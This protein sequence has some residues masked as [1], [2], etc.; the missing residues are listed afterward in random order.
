MQ[1]YKLNKKFKNYYTG[2]IES[3][4]FDYE[5][6]SGFPSIEEAKNSVLCLHQQPDCFL[7]ITFKH[8]IYAISME[9]QQRQMVIGS[10]KVF[11]LHNYQPT[12]YQNDPTSLLPF[13]IS[14]PRI[15]GHWRDGILRDMERIEGSTLTFTGEKSLLSDQFTR[16]AQHLLGMS[17][18]ATQIHV[19]Q[20]NCVDTYFSEPP[21]HKDLWAQGVRTINP[22]NGEKTYANC[23]IY[24]LDLYEKEKNLIS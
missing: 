8:L 20:L 21:S 13:I 16:H 23:S 3:I 17:F 11:V 2:R 18:F 5:V 12:I 6:F 4:T 9:T 14:Q 24:T 22:F 10:E 7:Y 15:T 19:Y 1:T